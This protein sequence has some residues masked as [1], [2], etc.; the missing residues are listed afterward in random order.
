MHIRSVVSC[1]QA[2]GRGL[3]GHLA[4]CHLFANTY[5]ALSRYW[6]SHL[7]ERK[8]SVNICRGPPWIWATLFMCLLAIID[9]H[10]QHSNAAWWAEPQIQQV[11]T[12]RFTVARTKRCYGRRWRGTAPTAWCHRSECGTAMASRQRGQRGLGGRPA[13]VPLGQPKISHGL[14]WV[15]NRM[16]VVKNRLNKQL[17]GATTRRFITA[18]TTARQR[19]LSWARWIHSTPPKPISLRSILIPSSHPRLGLSS[20]LFTSGFPTKTLYTFL[21]SPMRAT[22]PAHLILLDLICLIPFTVERL[23][24]VMVIK[25][26]LGGGIELL[27]IF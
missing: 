19:S 16:S 17:R 13:P 25:C 6:Q 27:N 4:G 9:E 1:G 7:L 26:F 12:A 2:D 23:K 14:S 24:F 8:L 10:R 3:L 5:N 18:F 21:P 15:R 11:A 20:G 22:C